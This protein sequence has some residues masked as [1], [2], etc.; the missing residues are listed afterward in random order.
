VNP[1]VHLELHTPDERGAS[2]FYSSL[3]GWQP[4]RITAGR[5]SYLTLHADGAIGAGVVGC[6]TARPLWIPYVTVERLEAMHQRA[7]GLGACAML[8]PREGP[9]GWRSVLRTPVG[10]EIALWQPKRGSCER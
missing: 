5:G 2:D 1:V 4:Q 8:G 7:L 6:T 9:A 3:L 10:G